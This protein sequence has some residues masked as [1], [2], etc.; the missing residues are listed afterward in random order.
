MTWLVYIK[1]YLPISMSM[2]ISKIIVQ[3]IIYEMISPTVVLLEDYVLDGM[4]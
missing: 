2:S 1:L 3:I 4:I